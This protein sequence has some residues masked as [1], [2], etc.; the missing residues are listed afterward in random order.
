MNILSSDISSISGRSSPASLCV[1]P[2]Q[3]DWFG[4][5]GTEITLSA[6]AVTQLVTRDVG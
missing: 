2:G 1:D 6:E 4:G 3:S 5:E